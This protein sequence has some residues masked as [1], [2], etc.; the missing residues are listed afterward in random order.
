MRLPGA[1]VLAAVLATA[2][3]AQSPP[4]RAAWPAAKVQAILERTAR[5]R[6]APDL[7]H[8]TAGERTAV[9]KLL[10]VGR[11]VQD[12]YELQRHRSAPTARA[13]LEKATGAPSRDLSTLYRLFQGPIAT[14]LE[15]TREP[16]LPVDP[17]PPGKNVY[18]WDLTESEFQAYLGAHPDDRAGLTHLRHVVRRADAAT[19]ARELAALAR[20]PVLDTLHPGL[21]SRLT[22]LSRTPD[23]A[24][25]YAL[26]YSVA[27]AD[28]SVRAHRLLHEAADAVAGDDEEFAR[29]LRNRARDLLTDDYEA[30]DAAWLKG[31]FK[32]LNAQSEA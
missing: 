8:L 15:N 4:P 16:F 9:A 30:G 25:L 17:A 31:R 12:V 6:L 2:V 14:T 1:L 27:Y 26:P 29:F 7:S 13:A 22:R 28:E 11:I 24:V 18:P 5:T 3:A 32:R 23:R 19:L 10:Q 20:H 21:T